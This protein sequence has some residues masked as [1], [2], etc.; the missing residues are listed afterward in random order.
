MA[1]SGSSTGLRFA[2]DAVSVP[3]YYDS[4]FTNSFGPSGG[5]RFRRGGQTA[6]PA[7]CHSM[8]IGTL[9]VAPN[10]NENVILF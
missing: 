6:P 2:N 4:S 8:Y 9:Y 1:K 7:A 5:P 3:G 10:V